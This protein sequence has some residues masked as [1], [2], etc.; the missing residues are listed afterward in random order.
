MDA[1]LLKEVGQY[2]YVNINGPS[3]IKVPPW[4]ENPLDKFYLYFAHHKGDYSKLAYVDRP[5]G[6][7]RIY[8][9]SISPVF[10]ILMTY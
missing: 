1:S 3:I 4:V 5:E 2:C 7:W 8:N 10:M 9:Y 6:P